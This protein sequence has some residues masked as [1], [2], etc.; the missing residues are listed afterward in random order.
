M[1]GR[2][3]A[4]KFAVS[5]LQKHRIL[6]SKQICLT[7]DLSSELFDKVPLKY[8]FD[9]FMYMAVRKKTLS[10]RWVFICENG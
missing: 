9:K 10:Y 8:D 7:K 3:Q 2:G 4:I 6:N 5:F 1:V